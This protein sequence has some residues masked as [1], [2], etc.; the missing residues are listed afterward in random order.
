MLL[1]ALKY[2]VE[3]KLAG[4]RVFKQISRELNAT[5]DRELADMGLSRCDVY[6]IAVQ[7]AR[8]AEDAARA[9]AATGKKADKALT[10]IGAPPQVYY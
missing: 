2:F 8:D 6:P 5:S 1:I 4:R 3:R 9:N 10:G 7:A